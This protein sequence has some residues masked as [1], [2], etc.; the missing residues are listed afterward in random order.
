MADINLHVVD[1]TVSTNLL[2]KQARN[3]EEGWCVIADYQSGG[4]GMGANRWESNCGENITG[5]LILKPVFV[6]PGECFLISM[7]V[8][9][10]IVS[11]LD[12][13]G[14]QASIKWPNDIYVDGKKLAGILI[15]NEFTAKAVTRTII[16]IGLNV[17]QHQFSDAPNPVSLRQITGQDFNVKAVAHQLFGNVYSRYLALAKSAD[18][19]VKMYHSHLLG[20]GEVLRYQDDIGQFT[21]EIRH[22]ETDGQIHIVDTSGILRTYYF[23][24]VKLV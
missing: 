5:S 21:G 8:S 2:A 11:F 7:A 14:V 9:L 15:E 1:E 19:V 12:D 16:G 6:T 3:A 20:L 13:L 4:R 10:G 22:V 17:N 23:K 18:H 24:E